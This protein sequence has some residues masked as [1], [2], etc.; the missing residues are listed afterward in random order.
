MFQLTEANM[1]PAFQLT[2][3]YWSGLKMSQED[4]HVSGSA[5]LCSERIWQYEVLLQQSHFSG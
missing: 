4:W 5:F 3:I 1:L 2:N